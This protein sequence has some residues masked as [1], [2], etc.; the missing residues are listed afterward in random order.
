MCGKCESLVQKVSI[1]LGILGFI[2]AVATRL[3]GLSPMGL[4]PRSFAAASGLLFL[5]SM[6]VGACKDHQHV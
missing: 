4:G 3:T 6:A 1:A 2:L 5:L